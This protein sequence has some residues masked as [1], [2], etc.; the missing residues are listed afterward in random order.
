VSRGENLGPFQR[1]YNALGF[2]SS[3]AK[4]PVGRNRRVIH[5]HFAGV[6]PRGGPGGRQCRAARQHAEGVLAAGDRDRPGVGFHRMK[7][8]KNLTERAMARI[9]AV[10]EAVFASDGLTLFLGAGINAD[11]APLWKDFLRELWD[12]AVKIGISPTDRKDSTDNVAKWIFNSNL[13]SLYEKASIIK[14]LLGPDRYRLAIR[15]I[16][17]GK[18][19]N[20][21]AKLLESVAAL[22]RSGRVQSVVT[23]NYDE[24]LEYRISKTKN[25]TVHHVH[26]VIPDVK[27]KSHATEEI[28]LSMDEYFHNM[29]KPFSWQ[30]AIQLNALT[31]SPCLFVGTSLTD[32][33]ML[34]L[35]TYARDEK[36]AGRIFALLA[37]EEYS[38]KVENEM[39]KLP[40]N[41]GTLGK[42]NKKQWIKEAVRFAARAKASLLQDLEV[43]MIMVES[44]VDLPVWVMNLARTVKRN[45]KNR[46]GKKK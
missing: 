28:V 40:P 46:K 16:L 11:K 26:G 23:F 31:G 41:A 21:P 42:I 9:P 7:A 35:L 37:K 5:F 12:Y 22:C 29:A 24:L 8:Q 27:Y 1:V 36:R 2:H 13:F 10:A 14:I 30:T 44:Y 43:E 33:N 17:Y 19:K 6:D 34:R 18:L 39:K 4:S 25:I 38:K 3:S 20:K 45:N 32:I 15:K